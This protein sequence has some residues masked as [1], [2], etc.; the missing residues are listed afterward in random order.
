MKRREMNKKNTINA[1]N[2]VFTENAVIVDG[3]PALKEGAAG[4]RRVTGEIDELDKKFIT[5]VDGKTS[6]KNLLEEELIEHLMPVKAALYAYAVRSKNEELRVLTKESES[7]LRK[8]PDPELLK[9]AELIIGESQKNL[10]DLASYKITAEVITELQEKITAF[11]TAIDG[12]D[13]G[14]A[15]RSALRI[16]L[17]EKFDE[18]DEI[19]ADQ[20]DQLI[21]LV[22]KSHPLFYDQY[23]TA[24][25]IKDLGGAHKAIEEEKKPDVSSKQ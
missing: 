18:A 4:L 14:F 5:S 25:T 8:M 21:E 20:L 9:K 2:A 1:L 13:T 22:R 19:I 10:P 15:N 3:Y 7:G 23:Q 16:A 11:G 12:K 6:S 24:R 17:T